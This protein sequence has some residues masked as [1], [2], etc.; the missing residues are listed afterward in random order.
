MVLAGAEPGRAEHLLEQLA[1]AVCD[2]VDARL[3]LDAQAGNWAVEDDGSLSLFDVSTPLMRTPD[4]RDRLDMSLFT[5]IYPAALQPLLRRVAHEIARPYHEPRSVLLDV[6][7]N[8]HK[9]RLDG[10]LPMFLA[11]AA[12][13]TGAPIE[14][15]R[16]C[17][18]S[19]ATARCGCCSS[20]CGAPT[21]PGSVTCAAAPTRSCWPR[22]TATGR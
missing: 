17:A 19:A 11:A 4:G 18:T 20:A 22:P 15:P 1:A 16:S 5:T 3:G 21:A 14:R 12:A 10:C 2:A 13:R 9:E 6:A 7:S 8:L